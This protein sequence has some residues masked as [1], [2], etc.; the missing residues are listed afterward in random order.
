M[1]IHIHIYVT[2][3]VCAS[4]HVRHH[5]PNVRMHVG[6]HAQCTYKQVFSEYV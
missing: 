4:M 3:Y 6:H 2:A 1:L 5:A